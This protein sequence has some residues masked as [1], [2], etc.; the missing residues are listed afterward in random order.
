MKPLYTYIRRTNVATGILMT[1]GMKLLQ[2]KIWYLRIAYHDQT[3]R[4]EKPTWPLTNFGKKE[5]WSRHYCSC[6]YMVMLWLPFKFPS[7]EA[8]FH[9]PKW[10][11][12]TSN[13]TVGGSSCLLQSRSRASPRDII[14]TSHSSTRWREVV[15]RGQVRPSETR[16]VAC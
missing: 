8:R 16:R 7:C 4:Y 2:Q 12:F 13:F 14:I 6:R 3:P 11:N 9:Q 15:S 1:N 10:N 5:I